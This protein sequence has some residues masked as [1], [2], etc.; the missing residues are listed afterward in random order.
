MPGSGAQPPARVSSG[1][2]AS[3][4]PGPRGH[5][6]RLAPAFGPGTGQRG[7]SHVGRSPASPGRGQRGGGWGAGRRSGRGQVGGWSLRRSQAGLYCSTLAAPSAR[8]RPGRAR[9]ARGARLPGLPPPPD[10]ATRPEPSSAPG[11]ASAGPSGLRGRACSGGARGREAAGAGG[12]GTPLRER[13]VPAGR[14]PARSP[15]GP[16]SRGEAARE[17]GP[18]PHL[19][20]T[21]RP[22]GPW[23]RDA[24][25]G[26]RRAGAG[27]PLPSGA[28]PPR[29]PPGRPHGGRRVGPEG[30]RR[31]PRGHQLAQPEPGRAAPADGQRGRHGPALEHRGRPVL[32]TP[33][34]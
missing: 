22:A 1:A 30:L 13:E 25:T 24:A 11:A 18:P 31:P 34:R 2:R 12:A 3:Q 28:Q 27:A 23:P 33:A 16:G 26:S 17:R 14:P 6:L 19:R 9:G 4:P 7:E 20:R 8:R 5:L 10:P 15:R 32:R 29:L 21:P